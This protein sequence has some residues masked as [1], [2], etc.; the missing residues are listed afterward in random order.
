MK[1]HVDFIASN[2]VKRYVGEIN[3]PEGVAQEIAGNRNS[4]ALHK[5]EL[6]LSSEL[7]I[8]QLEIS[9]LGPR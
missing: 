6:T 3:I 2:G 4:A 9:P 5:F 8:G 1:L 7:Q